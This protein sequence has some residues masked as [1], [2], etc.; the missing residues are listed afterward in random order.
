[1]TMYAIRK[2]YGVPAKRG[3]KIE[4]LASDGEIIQGTITRSAQGFRLRAI[5]EG[6]KKSTLFHPTYRLHYLLDDGSRFIPKDDEA[7]RKK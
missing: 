1:M 7:G 2:R 6:N 4:Y 3:M 5:M